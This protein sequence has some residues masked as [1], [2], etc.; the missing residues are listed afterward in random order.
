MPVHARGPTTHAGRWA[1]VSRRAGTRR[2]PGAPHPPATTRIRGGAVPGCSRAPRPASHGTARW[3]RTAGRGR[4]P[5]RLPV[6]RPPGSELVLRTQQERA[7]RT[8]EVVL[9]QVAQPLDVAFVG[10]I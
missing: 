10:D 1:P 7:R 6:V 5:L 2:A 4:A 9:V 3:L 8:E